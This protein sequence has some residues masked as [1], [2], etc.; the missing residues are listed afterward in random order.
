MTLSILTV[1]YYFFHWLFESQPQDISVC[2]TR[3]SYSRNC[4]IITFNSAADLYTEARIIERTSG[5]S[6][7]IKKKF[8][9]CIRAKAARDSSKQKSPQIRPVLTRMNYSNSRARNRNL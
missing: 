7:L 9:S 8:V 2:A 3:I 4:E 5:G 6:S 1:M